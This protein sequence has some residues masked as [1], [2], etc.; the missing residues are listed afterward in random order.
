MQKYERR[1]MKKLLLSLSFLSSY[2][3]IASDVSYITIWNGTDQDLIVREKEYI[4]GTPE[5]T[6]LPRTLK[7]SEMFDS[8]TNAIAVSVKTLDRKFSQIFRNASRHSFIYTGMII[9]I[10]SKDG[11]IVA[12]ELH[13]KSRLF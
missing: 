1:S 10:V 8:S 12:E 7:P 6:M 4:S 9:N 13:A 11:E 3:L 5:I 2:A